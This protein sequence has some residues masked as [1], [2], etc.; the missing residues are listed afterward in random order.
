MEHIVYGMGSVN[1]IT[2]GGGGGG[3][4]T[5]WARLI[6]HKMS[7]VLNKMML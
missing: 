5:L 6:K 1:C 2:G 4:H 3:P 7:F